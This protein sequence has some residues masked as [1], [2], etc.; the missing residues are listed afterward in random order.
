MTQ[1][2]CEWL[3]IQSQASQLRRP[4]SLALTCP[5][6]LSFPSVHDLHFQFC[7]GLWTWF[8][9]SLPSVTSL[10]LDLTSHPQ[11]PVFSSCSPKKRRNKAC[12]GTTSF[13]ARRSRDRMGGHYHADTN[14]RCT[15][16][17]GVPA[18]LQMR[19]KDTE[20]PHP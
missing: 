1:Q 11:C 12:R 17:T 19:V 16:K 9:K 5:P 15:H 14:E 8:E 4:F 2:L 20:N 10:C 13:Q 6:N 3:C 18:V 7:H